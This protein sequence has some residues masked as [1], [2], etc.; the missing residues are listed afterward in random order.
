VAQ[1]EP[2]VAVEEHLPVAVS[3]LGAEATRAA[4]PNFFDANRGSINSIV[5]VAFG[6]NSLTGS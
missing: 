2:V 1:Q 4:L 5:P 6:T 3:L